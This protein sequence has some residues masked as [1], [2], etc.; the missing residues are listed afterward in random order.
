MHKL[1]CTLTAAGSLAL[2]ATVVQAQV[3]RCTDPATGKVTY[4]DGA[5]QSGAS[6]REVEARKSPADI[7][8]ERAEAEQALE[9]KQ[10]RLQAEAAAQ[11]QAARNAPAPAPTAQPRPDYAR[12]PECARSRRNLDTAISAGDAG[13]YEQN[14]R[15]E[16]AQRQVDLDCLGPAAYAELEKTRAMRPVVVPPTTIVLPPRHPRPV[17]PP[18]VAP[19]TPPKFTQCNVFRCYDS[20]GNSHPR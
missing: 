3:V 20:Q 5:C 8:R 13:T 11:A 4:T 2:A 12:S 10:Q 19:P 6:A 17:P 15:V 1:F 18:V 7:Q 14:Q 9:R 16:A